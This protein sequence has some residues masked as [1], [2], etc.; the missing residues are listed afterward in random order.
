VQHLPRVPLDAPLER[1]RVYHVVMAH[2]AW[3]AIYSGKE[4]NCSP[5]ISRHAEPR[6]S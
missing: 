6:R 2:D 1:G 5:I 4:C 3:C